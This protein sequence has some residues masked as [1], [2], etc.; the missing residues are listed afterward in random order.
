MH[1]HFSRPPRIWVRA[2]TPWVGTVRGKGGRAIGP[3][4]APAFWLGAPGRACADE[5]PG[6]GSGV[7]P[8]PSQGTGGCWA[9]W[10]PPQSA[11]PP[12]MNLIDAIVVPGLDGSGTVPAASPR[13]WKNSR[14]PLTSGGSWLR[15][16]KTVWIVLPPS[17]TDLFRKP[18]LAS[19]TSDRSEDSR[20]SWVSRLLR[21]PALLLMSG[22]AT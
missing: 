2:C 3:L 22:K 7:P 9:S 20:A 5:L 11:P 16:S 4:G 6:T 21:L 17:V 15:R 18:L 12:T 10:P 13:T 19:S 14:R 1:R 8:G